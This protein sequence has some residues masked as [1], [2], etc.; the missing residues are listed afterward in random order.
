M[1][2]SDIAP[3]YGHFGTDWVAMEATETARSAA[4]RRAIPHGRF[5]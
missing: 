5:H 1:S 2:W 3:L 4:I